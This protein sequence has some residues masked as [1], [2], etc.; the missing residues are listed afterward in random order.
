MGLLIPDFQCCPRLSL[1]LSR[2]DLTEL[3]CWIHESSSLRTAG[4]WLCRVLSLFCST[5]LCSSTKHTLYKCLSSCKLFLTSTLLRPVCLCVCRPFIWLGHWE[6]SKQCL[7]SVFSYL[8]SC[9]LC[10]QCLNGYHSISKD[11]G[12]SLFVYGHE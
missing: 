7:V 11:L 6:Q 3:H 8:I 5:W 2:S 10:L 12:S 9:L 4:W 1:C